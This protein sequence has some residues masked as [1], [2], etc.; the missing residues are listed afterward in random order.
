MCS[1]VRAPHAPPG[2]APWTRF[3]RNFYFGVLNEWFCG[4]NLPCCEK[5]VGSTVAPNPWLRAAV[6]LWAPES[7]EG[8]K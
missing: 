8:V 7:E 6:A 4:T 1:F 3:L 2:A 5:L